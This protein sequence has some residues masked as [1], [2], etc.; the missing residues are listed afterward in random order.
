MDRK[1]QHLF[2]GFF[3]FH[4]HFYM[5]QQWELRSASA[6]Y[7]VNYLS[8]KRNNIAC[9]AL[10]RSRLLDRFGLNV[11]TPPDCANVVVGIFNGFNKVHITI[12]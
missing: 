12:L 5:K 9:R 4:K 11:T 2:G 10:K 7:R 8:S 1:L 6:L 3:P